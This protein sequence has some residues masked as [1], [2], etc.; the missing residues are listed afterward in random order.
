M[1]ERLEQQ[2]GALHHIVTELVKQYQFRDRQAICCH[3]I[4]VSQ[5]YALA[6]LDESGKLSMG[7]LAKHL[8]LTVSTMTRIIDQ[9]VARNLVHRWADPDDHRVCHVEFTEQGRSLLEKIGGELLET[10]KEILSKIKPQDRETLIFALKE[11]A[12]AVDQWMAK[13]RRHCVWSVSTMGE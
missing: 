13:G 2:A 7:D 6:T 3:G 10:E 9:L 11:L 1:T 8:Y 5:Y 12:K 4:S